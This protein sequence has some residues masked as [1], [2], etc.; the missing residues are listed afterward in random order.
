LYRKY[1]SII[2]LELFKILPDKFYIV[3]LS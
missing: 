1:C 3:V 2:E